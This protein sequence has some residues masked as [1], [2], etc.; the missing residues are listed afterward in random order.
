MKLT[1]AGKEYY[2]A[3]GRGGVTAKKREGDGATPAGSYRVLGVYYRPDKTEVPKSPFPTKALQKDDIWVDDPNHPLYNQP[4]KASD[5]EPGVSHEQLWRDD[6]LYDIVVDL[7]YNRSPA[8]P[9]KGSAIFIHLA[10]DQKKPENTPTAGCIGMKRA[11]LLELL[12]S[13]EAGSLIEIK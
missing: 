5:I 4:A 2:V 10:R 12:G 11:D 8:V 7:D 6:H 3:V 13:L 1:L 9:G